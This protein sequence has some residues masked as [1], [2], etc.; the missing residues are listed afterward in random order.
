MK[1]TAEELFDSLQRETSIAEI[2]ELYKAL[3][4]RELGVEAY[5]EELDKILT[6]VIALDYWETDTV[7]SFINP[8]L[9]D[10]AYDRLEEA[11]IPEDKQ[12]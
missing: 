11:N 10:I 7:E 5:T 3:L 6:D 9:V 2:L 8:D 4:A 1:W 12:H